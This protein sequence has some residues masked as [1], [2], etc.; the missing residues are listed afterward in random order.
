MPGVCVL[1]VC[2]CESLRVCSAMY[3]SMYKLCMCVCLHTC[4]HNFSFVDDDDDDD[5]DDD[6]DSSQCEFLSIRFYL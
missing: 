2:A 1:C 4:M 3:V 5:G 6:Y